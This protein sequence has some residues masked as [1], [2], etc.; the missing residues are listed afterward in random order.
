MALSLTREQLLERL[1]DPHRMQLLVIALN[2]DM[3]QVFPVD[4]KIQFPINT[5][6]INIDI[7]EALIKLS[8]KWLLRAVDL[9]YD[10]NLDG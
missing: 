4:Y 10:E 3:K 8:S 1:D 2:E 7:G 6:D 9:A 5:N